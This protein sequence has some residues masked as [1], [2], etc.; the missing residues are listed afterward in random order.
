VKVE[1]AAYDARC[2]GDGGDVSTGQSGPANLRQRGI[3]ESRARFL[4]AGLSTASTHCS[5]ADDGVWR[6][7]TSTVTTFIDDR[8]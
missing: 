6:P 2:A 5:D 7:H 1:G 3:E 4:H 8:Q